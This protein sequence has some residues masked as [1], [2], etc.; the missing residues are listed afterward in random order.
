M[1]RP[2]LLV[3]AGN[4]EKLRTALLYGADAVYIGVAG[5]SLRTDRA[6]MDM[7]DLA[8]GIREA[9]ERGAKV[10]GAMNTLAREED[11][12]QVAR[13][14]PCLREMGLDAVILSDPGVLRV[15]RRVTPDL[16]VH[17]STQANTTNAEA[18]QFWLEQ[19]V[20]RIVLARELTLTEVKAVAAAVPEVD[21]ELFVHGAMCMAYSG[22]CFLSAYQNGRSANRGDCTQPCRWEYLLTEA[23]R[24]DQPMLIQE[25]ERFSYLLSSKDLRMI[26]FLPEILAAGVTAL[27]IEGRMKTVY[28]VATVTRA[29]RRALDEMLRHHEGYKCSQEYLDEL[30]KVSHRGYTTG[31]YFTQGMIGETSPDLK[32]QQTHDLVGTVLSYDANAGYVAVGVRNRLDR[33]DEVELLLP[34]TDIR[35]DPHQ[36]I[37]EKGAPIATAHNGFT[38]RFPLDRPAPAGA[39]LR[40]RIY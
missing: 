20:S 19:G 11:L 15:V 25:D 35:L 14:A 22:R 10:Y 2:E 32:Y 29:Y 31:F 23:T 30:N 4:L 9:H 21:L 1:K 28:Y 24:P 7:D 39:V 16:P 17:L 36:M 38:V 6:E 26:E 8:V 33:E 37:D 12:A 34:E 27:K 13:I 40:R 5:L 3:P 18:V